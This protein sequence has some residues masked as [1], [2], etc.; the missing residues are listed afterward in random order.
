MDNEPEGKIESV[1]S[2]AAA[3]GALLEAS[4]AGA[5]AGTAA[6]PAACALMEACRMA[7]AAAAFTWG[8]VSTS[9]NLHTRQKRKSRLREG[10]TNND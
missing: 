4:A 1:H 3:A 2:P 5:A 6:E 10:P 9:P 7:A 8:G